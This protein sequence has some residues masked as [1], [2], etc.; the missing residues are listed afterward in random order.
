MITEPHI[1]YASQGQK[2]LLLEHGDVM[3][4][5][6]F[7]AEW[8]AYKA[9]MYL[10]EKELKDTCGMIGIDQFG[11]EPVVDT[12][13]ENAFLSEENKEWLTKLSQKKRDF[14]AQWIP[15]L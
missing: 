8:E 9:A 6:L 7:H 4:E 10:Y 12:G 2:D 14:E 5:E 1:L 13:N 3:D 15:P 11:M